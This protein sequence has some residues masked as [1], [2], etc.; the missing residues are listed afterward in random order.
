M[1][2]ECREPG[3]LSRSRGR[4][5]RRTLDFDDT[6]YAIGGNKYTSDETD[7]NLYSKTAEN[8]CDEQYEITDDERDRY[9]DYENQDDEEC[10][11]QLKN[12]DKYRYVN[13]RRRPR[14]FEK[15]PDSKLRLTINSELEQQPIPKNQ[16]NEFVLKQYKMPIECD[17]KVEDCYD[18]DTAQ[19]NIK[20]S[21]REPICVYDTDNEMHEQHRSDGIHNARS[22]NCL[23]CT[24]FKHNANHTCRAAPDRIER[25]EFERSARNTRN[26][27]NPE[28][29]KKQNFLVLD[30]EQVLCD[31]G[32][33]NDGKRIPQNRGRGYQMYQMKCK[34]DERKL[35][36]S[37]EEERRSRYELNPE[38]RETSRE[39]P[40][41]YFSSN[42]DNRDNNGGMKREIEKGVKVILKMFAEIIGKDLIQQCWNPDHTQG[43]IKIL[44]TLTILEMSGHH[45]LTFLRVF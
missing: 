25:T 1:D 32:L 44:T 35:L 29:R 10:L 45:T 28:P 15:V 4:A 8:S 11:K 5:A 42:R 12:Q 17:S 43:A 40:I 7:T 39:R 33:D 34:D 27:R 9:C 22:N 16:S 26:T 6:K 3:R 14:Y 18:E 20:M 19:G 30:D 41:E 23:G 38:H 21:Y 37:L 24:Q 31:E 36:R 2:P 13:T